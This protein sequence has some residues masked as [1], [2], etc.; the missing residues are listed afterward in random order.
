MRDRLA[1]TKA[2]LEPVDREDLPRLPRERARE[3]VR[4][5]G[6]QG[7]DRA[8]DPA[9]V[10][11]SRSASARARASASD[12]DAQY[13]WPRRRAQGAPRELAVLQEPA[14]TSPSG[15]TGARSG[16]RARPRAA[17]SSWT[18]RRALK[19]AEIPVG[20]QATDVAFSPDGT[21]AYVTNR[22][23]D[24]VVGHRRGDAQGPAAPSRWPTSRTGVALDP[25][26]KTLFVLDTAFDAVSVVDLATRQG[27]ERLAASR[28]PGRLALSPDGKRCWSRTPSPASAS[29]AR[30]RC[31]RS[32]SS[33]P[34]GR[35]SRTGGSC[36]RRTCCSASP[37]TRA[38]S[39]RWP[40]STA[41]RT[42]FR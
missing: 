32:P 25:T 30:R 33:T 20:G 3:A 7:E 15:P 11:R 2:G 23:N 41:P 18:R 35:G 1:A 39:S 5:R 29:S 36:R 9:R 17:S 42:S 8:P 22:L 38:V 34:R 31:P 19:V 12:L 27:D 14:S 37:G 21:R 4:L 26:G 28:N 10:G 24:S 16:S 6:G 13:G 40:R